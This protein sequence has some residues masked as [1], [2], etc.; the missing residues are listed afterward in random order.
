MHRCC[1]FGENESNTLLDIVLTMFRDAHTDARTNRTKTVSL[2]PHYVGRRHKK[3]GEG[4][5]GGREGRK[6]RERER[7][8]SPLASNR[9]HKSEI[10]YKTRHWRAKT[11]IN[12]IKHSV[13]SLRQAGHFLPQEAIVIVT[14]AYMAGYCTVCRLI[15]INYA[16]SIQLALVPVTETARN[17][18]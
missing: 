11:F 7:E 15:C 6:K 17:C 2:R 16:V 9:Y 10:L 12:N 1:K 18:L 14:S 5:E 13:I 3:E 4:K 8:G